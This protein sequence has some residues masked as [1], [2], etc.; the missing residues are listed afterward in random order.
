MIDLS[1]IFER[2]LSLRASVSHP[3]FPLDT[4]AL[5]QFNLVLV[6]MR[7]VKTLTP[8]LVFICHLVC[9]L[10]VGSSGLSYFL[11]FSEVKTPSIKWALKGTK[12]SKEKIRHYL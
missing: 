11:S 10:R 4:A 9:G 5:E 2:C 7:Y 12:A 1:T 3:G 6:R 8:L